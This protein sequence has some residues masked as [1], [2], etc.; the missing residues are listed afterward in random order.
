MLIMTMVVIYGFEGKLIGKS[1]YD[2]CFPEIDDVPKLT[3][4]LTRGFRY[5]VPKIPLCKSLFTF[6]HQ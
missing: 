3:E 4:D 2:Y 1:E 5:I 6:L